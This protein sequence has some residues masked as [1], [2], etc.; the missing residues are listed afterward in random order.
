MDL[1]VLDAEPGVLQG[2]W[3]PVRDGSQVPG[4]LRPDRSPAGRVHAGRHGGLRGRPAGLGC[5]VVDYAQF[6]DQITE[7][8]AAMRAAAVAAGPDA[9]VPTCPKWTVRELVRHLTRVQ[10]WSG[11]A[12]LTDPEGERPHP[13]ESPAEWDEL[14]SFWDDQVG[15]LVDTLRGRQPDAPAW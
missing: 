8:T 1:P 14:L 12:L 6:V 3:R 11:R 7:Q 2:T 10:Q 5:R 9:E 15:I 13:D 4:Q